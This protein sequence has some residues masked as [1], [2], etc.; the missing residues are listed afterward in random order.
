MTDG[1][2]PSA[3]PLSGM[4]VLVAEDDWFIADALRWAFEKAGA[5]VVGLAATVTDAEQIVATSTID[6]AV[7]DITL[8]QKG[9]AAP[10]AE[11]LAKR[12]TKVVI[13]SAKECE[14]ALAALVHAVLLKP[15]DMK[16]LI[17]TLA[18]S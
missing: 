15:F 1:N 16:D 13:I 8:Q 9:S 7:M 17:A 14:P 2:Q 12:G 11:R 6:A 18:S 4:R 3:L 5:E 10:L